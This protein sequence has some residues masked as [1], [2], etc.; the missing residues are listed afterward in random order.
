[1][2]HKKKYFLTQ[3]EYIL[4]SLKKNRKRLKPNDFHNELV[5]INGEDKTQ[6]QIKKRN[7]VLLK[8]NAENFIK[9]ETNMN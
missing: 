5:F 7:I 3:N 2:S 6:I 4:I 9:Q 1:M 8:K